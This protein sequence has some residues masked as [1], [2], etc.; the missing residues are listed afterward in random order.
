MF[1]RLGNDWTIFNGLWNFYRY[2]VYGHLSVQAIFHF[3]NSPLSDR[4]NPKIKVLRPCAGNK[5]FRI[6]SARWREYKSH[7]YDGNHV[8]LT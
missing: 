5:Y 6:L 1:A 3:T 2:F 7:T 8:N 4:Q